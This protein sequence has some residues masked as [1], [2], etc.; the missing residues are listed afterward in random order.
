M[1][2]KPLSIIF[3]GDIVG[4]LG[5]KTV[6]E[7]VPKWREHYKA[8]LVIANGENMAH[9]KG[10][11]LL[12]AQEVLASGIDWLTSGD[13]CFDQSS[14]IEACFNG[15][16]PILRPENYADEAPGKGHAV[17]KIGDHEI[18]LLNL[19]GRTFMP[20]HYNCPFR[21]ADRI[22]ANFTEKNFSAIIIDI[23]AETT[24]E[25]IALRH[26]L[27][28]KI[29]ALLGTHTH[30]PTADA[31]ITDQGTAYITD[32]GMTGDADGVIGVGADAIV[33]SFLS[34]TKVSHILADRG[35]AQCG[36]VHLSIDPETGRCL[37]IT[38]LNERV[39]F[40]S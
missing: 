39:S 28:G 4:K 40:A 26:F 17:I 24:A 36:A 18:L 31:Q 8:D 25:K 35:R 15:E 21:A 33:A 6:A 9:G 3:I 22:L 32:V 10:I 38:P 20:R 23:H 11:S 1:N 14:S 12:T 13:H 37:K 34:Q 2:T 19:I 5:R 16:L 27:N 29:S 7:L 30:V